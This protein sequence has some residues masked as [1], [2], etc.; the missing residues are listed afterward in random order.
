MLIGDILVA[1]AGATVRDTDDLQ[2]QLGPDR[3]GQPTPVK[4]LRGGEARDVI[5]NVGERT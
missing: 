4:V 1:V 2:G 3:V 5:V